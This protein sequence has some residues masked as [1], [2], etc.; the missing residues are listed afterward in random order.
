M[1]PVICFNTSYN[2]KCKDKNIFR[3]HTWYDIYYQIIDL[4]N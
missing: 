4:I 2:K 3:E 1:I